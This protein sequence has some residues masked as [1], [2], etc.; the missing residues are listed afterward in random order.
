MTIMI[1]NG[2]EHYI[3]DTEKGEEPCPTLYYR[4]EENKE[5]FSVFVLKNKE[6]YSGVIVGE[7][8]EMHITDGELTHIID[9][10][11]RT[12]H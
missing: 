9:Y 1:F 11:K 2:I 3:L 5:D 6:L 4:L 7:D 8:G 12:L 10:S